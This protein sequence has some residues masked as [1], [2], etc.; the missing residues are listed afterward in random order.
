LNRRTKTG[1]A[2]NLPPGRYHSVR[3]S[4]AVGVVKLNRYGAASERP[5]K[6]AADAAIV[7]S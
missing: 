3:S 6:A 4:R 7:T 1:A 2:S 5:L